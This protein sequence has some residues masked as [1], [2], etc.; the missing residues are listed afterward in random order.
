MHQILNISSHLTSYTFKNQNQQK[1]G[2]WALEYASQ[3]EHQN[4]FNLLHLLKAKKYITIN[5]IIELQDVHQQYNISIH[6]TSYT[7]ENPKPTKPKVIG[8]QLMH[9]LLAIDTLFTSY[10]FKKPKPIEIKLMGF[11]MMTN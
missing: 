11:K 1:H 9:Q 3:I 5:K 10:T 6:L 8:L 2:Y 4:T 7:S